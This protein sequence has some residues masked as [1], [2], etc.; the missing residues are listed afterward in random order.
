MS[1]D[2]IQQRQAS[3][4]AGRSWSV[5][6]P[7]PTGNIDA[8]DRALLAGVYGVGSVIVDPNLFYRYQR[9]SSISLGRVWM[10]ML[11]YPDGVIANYDRAQLAWSYWF[12][13]VVIPTT[14]NG[15]MHG[16]YA[17]LPPVM[18]FDEQAPSMTFDAE[19]PVMTFTTEE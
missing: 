19:P 15:L 10:P 6:L 18:I 5:V 2:S 12:R 17:A 3:I 11:P 8:F 9:A 16:T 14:A 13:P 4:V 7:F 1:L